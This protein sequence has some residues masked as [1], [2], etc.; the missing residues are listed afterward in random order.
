MNF[1]IGM[2]C[3]VSAVKISCKWIHYEK[4]LWII[5][6]WKFLSKDFTM[7]L[8]QKIYYGNLLYML[9]RKCIVS[10]FTKLRDCKSFFYD[11]TL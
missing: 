3:N 9:L 4:L 7:G 2:H 5:V 8:M 11:N 6:P 10:D 1:T